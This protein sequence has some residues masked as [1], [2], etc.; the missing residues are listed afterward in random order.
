MPPLVP[1]Q[2]LPGT[3]DYGATNQYFGIKPGG[4]GNAG[5]PQNG[6]DFKHPR[7]QAHEHK[8][9][10]EDR[11][12]SKQ[13]IPGCSPWMLVKTK[14]SRRF[15]HNP[16]SRESLWR[17]PQEV[18][19][20]VIELDR[21]ERE[22]RERR[23]R[24]ERSDSE[25]DKEEVATVASTEASAK[26]SKP[27][28]VPHADDS[29]EYEEVEVTDDED[30]EGTAKRLKLEGE[31]KP[32]GPVEFNEDDIAYQLASMNQDFGDQGEEGGR[33]KDHDEER[34]NEEDAVALF[35]D[36]LDDYHINPYT[37]WESIIEE[38][39]I[40]DD[41]R[42]TCLATTK[43]RK[44]AWATWSK[45][46]IQRSKEQRERQEKKDPRIPYLAFLQN[47]ATPKLYW[48]EFKRKFK[49]E[50]EMR[51][52]KLLDKDREKWYREYINRMSSQS[53]AP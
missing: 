19:K 46:K 26:E 29:D 2:A 42:Y 23:E 30:E 6:A 40:I 22:K 48:P 52:T 1:V 21:K 9:Q 10:L 24:G 34:L 39:K 18:M 31:D 15:V 51:D 12:K 28:N 45:D 47:N 8:P 50:P 13:L 41:E 4:F 17:F 11:P 49:K 33:E 35:K 32:D 5:Y 36:L 16:K 27:D 20:C 53:Q 43:A 3:P 25:G 44:E 37:P 7:W 38:G 14:L